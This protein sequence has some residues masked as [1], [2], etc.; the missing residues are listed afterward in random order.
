LL[1]INGYKYVY[2]NKLQRTQKSAKTLFLQFYFM[3]FALFFAN[4]YTF[5]S[6]T[7]GFWELKAVILQRKS[8]M[9]V[10]ERDKNLKNKVI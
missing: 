6:L 1:L 2:I 7:P 10:P 9:I 5:F 4:F 3:F 8:K